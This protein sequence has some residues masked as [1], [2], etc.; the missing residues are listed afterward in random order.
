MLKHLQAAQNLPPPPTENLK[1]CF[2]SQLVMSH[3]PTPQNTPHATFLWTIPREDL[4]MPLPIGSMY[5]ICTYIYH[6]SKPKVSKYTNPM[7][8]I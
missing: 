5:V 4:I 7:D 1:K 8:P 2:P 6:K 3:D